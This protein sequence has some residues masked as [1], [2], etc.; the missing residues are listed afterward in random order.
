M[1]LNFRNRVLITIFLACLICTGAAVLVAYLRIQSLGQEDLVSKSQ[2]ILSRLEVGREYIADMGV[3]AGQIERVKAK[4]PDGIVPKEEKETILKAVPIFAAFRLGQTRAEQENYRF[5]IITT[6][7][8]NKD[9]KAEGQ[10]LDWLK[11]FENDGSLKEI[12]QF[13]SNADVLNVA[14]PV[15]LSEKQGCLVCHG[16]QATSPWG[17][18]KDILG[19]DMENMKDGDLK[20]AFVIKSSLVPVHER[21]RDALL[22]ILMW[23]ALITLLALALGFLIVRG[24]LKKLAQVIDGVTSSSGQVNSAAQQVS[25]SSQSMAEGASEQAASLEETSSTLDEM[26]STTRLNADHAKEAEA[27]ANE[28]RGFTHQGT[29]A[30]TRMSQ[31]ISNIRD[32]SSKTANIIKTIDEIAFQTNLL[33]LNAAVE[34]ARAGDAG[35]GFAVVAEEVRN[36]AQR[37]AE[38]AKNTNDLIEESQQRAEMGVQVSGEVESVLTKTKDAIQKVAD[39]V[40]EVATASDEQARGAD[41]INTAV[42]QMDRVTQA[43]AAN[44]EESAAASEELS[45]QATELQRMVNELLAVVHGGAASGMGGVRQAL[46]HDEAERRFLE[47]KV[48]VRGPGNGHSRLRPGRPSAKAGAED[49]GDEE[50]PTAPPQKHDRAKRPAGSLREKIREETRLHPAQLPKYLDELKDSDFQEM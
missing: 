31:A 33:A 16:S 45:S 32:A 18:G 50:L 35:K 36:L 8:R 11:R 41:Q 40:R 47:H 12:V 13:D 25:E 29:E 5:R 9:N 23:A 14:R 15:R 27:L 49:A 6:S 22:N 34:A 7:Q 38:A 46:A 44:A 17:N 10:E 2:A 19:Q 3:M 20:G 37:S 43:N 21:S 28:A 30:M 26:A 39:L 48:Q 4:Y 24:P 1:N 42:S